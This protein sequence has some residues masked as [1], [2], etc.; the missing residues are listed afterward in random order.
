M[1][2]EPIRSSAS[3]DSRLE[4]RSLLVDLVVHCSSPSYYL[5]NGLSFGLSCQLEAKH[6]VVR[7]RCGMGEEGSWKLTF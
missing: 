6:I 5:S 1:V 4:C 2:D 7:D 3:F